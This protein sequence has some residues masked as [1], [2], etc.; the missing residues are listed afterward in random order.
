MISVSF[1]EKKSIKIPVRLNCSAN[2]LFILV[3]NE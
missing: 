2:K 1:V 3:K